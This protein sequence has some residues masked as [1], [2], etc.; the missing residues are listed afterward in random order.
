MKEFLAEYQE[1]ILEQQPVEILGLEQEISLMVDGHHFTGRIDR[2]ER[3]GDG[4]T[5]ILDYKIRQDDTP[6]KVAWKKFNP[7]ERPSWPGAIGSLQL[8]MYSLLYSRHANE[9]VSNI[10][11]SYLFLGRN[12][13][14]K[15]IET[16]LS[17]DGMV[18]EPMHQNLHKV[19]VQLAEEIKNPGV[20]FR[21]TEDQKKECPGCPYQT[22]CG[23]LWAK[24][25]RW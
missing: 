25:G 14:D 24:E 12:Y 8:P 2:I 1:R 11:P 4:K 13:L 9:A 5:Y 16:G 23:T 10:V 21:P 19:I 7:D 17:K 15:T 22:I 6:Y 20:P 18:S 3:R